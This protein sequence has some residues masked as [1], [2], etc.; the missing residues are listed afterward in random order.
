MSDPQVQPPLT[1]RIQCFYDFVPN[2]A[3]FAPGATVEEMLRE[4]NGD[5]ADLMHNVL[6]ADPTSVMA[7]VIVI[8]GE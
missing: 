5:A 8:H 7:D 3:D 2:R 4:C 1:F 6:N